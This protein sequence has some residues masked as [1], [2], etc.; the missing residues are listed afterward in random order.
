MSSQATKDLPSTGADG[1]SKA[2][3]GQLGSDGRLRPKLLSGIRGKMFRDL[4]Q[5]AIKWSAESLDIARA[6]YHAPQLERPH[7]LEDRIYL[8]K[9]GCSALELIEGITQQWWASRASIERAALGEAL[10]DE[11]SAG[12]GPLEALCGFYGRYLSS[13]GYHMVLEFS[14]D[15]LE[16]IWRIDARFESVSIKRPQDEDDFYDQMACYLDLRYGWKWHIHKFL[17]SQRLSVVEVQNNYMIGVRLGEPGSTEDP[18]ER[19]DPHLEDAF[20][21]F[22]AERFDTL[23]FLNGPEAGRLPFQ[24]ERYHSWLPEP[25]HEGLNEGRYELFV[26]ALSDD[27]FRA[28]EDMAELRQVEVALK[29]KGQGPQLKLHRGPISITRDFSLIYLKTIHSGRSFS[30]G[31]VDFL[32]EDVERV[33]SASELY[34]GLNK[35]I[36]KASA[37]HLSVEGDSLKIF[38]GEAL[39]ADVPLLTWAELGAFEGPEGALRLLSLLGGERDESGLIYWRDT[40]HPLDRCPLCQEG[41]QVLRAVRP[42]PERA[43]AEL[44][45][46][47]VTFERAGAWGH[48]L[49]SCPQHSLPI[50]WASA[51]RLEEVISAQHYRRL[52]VRAEHSE[53]GVSVLWA[54]E[55][56]GLLLDELGRES[57][58]E[59]GALFAHALY[60]DI[61]ALSMA[62]LTEAQ[63]REAR[64]RAEVLGQRVNPSRLWPLDWAVELS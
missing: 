36:A 39:R 58:R 40:D 51:P 13:S 46:G 44:T 25:W 24:E 23:E 41:A 49:L 45:S 34:F 28:V 29:D 56:A 17:Q 8:P 64:Q 43:H 3:K 54:E 6:Y 19:E 12:E 1:E 50:T 31:A 11:L 10:S 61:V 2:P 32:R 27:F 14:P 62:P 9:A 42:R 38:E 52:E 53:E 59:R 22:D 33:R 26:L 4:R 60:P 18:A 37:H 16:H 7:S 47:L 5:E 55:L 35:L 48:Y 20:S 63:L 21:R 15:G 57:L 30:E